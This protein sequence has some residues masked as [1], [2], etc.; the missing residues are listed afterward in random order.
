VSFVSRLLGESFEWITY[1]LR[2]FFGEVEGSFRCCSNSRNLV[3]KLTAVGVRLS[4][5][6]Y[7]QQMKNMEKIIP[8]LLYTQHRTR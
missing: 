2:V 1:I 4:I 8:L 3:D 6:Y 7:H 5:Y